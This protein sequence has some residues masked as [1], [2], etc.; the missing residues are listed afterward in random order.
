ML[1]VK[2][3]MTLYDIE[4]IRHRGRQT[5]TWWDCVKNDMESLGLSPK[6]M[7]NLGI[8]G[9][10]ESRGQL[11]NPG[12]PGKMPLK[13][14]ICVYYMYVLSLDGQFWRSRRHK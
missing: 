2:M 8:N 6:R 5:K 10:G 12:S 14:I 11:A 1:T 13:R 9:E 3:I 4:E 7:L